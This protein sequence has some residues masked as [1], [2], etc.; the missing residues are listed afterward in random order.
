M[1][2]DGYDDLDRALAHALQLD[3]RAPFT[4]IAEVLGVSD[5]TVARRYTRLRTTGTIRVLGLTDPMAVG[6]VVWLVRVRCLPDTALAVAEALA[7]RTDTSWVN[8]LSDGTE[9]AASTRAAHGQE[10][11]ALL[12]RKLPQTPRVVG[13]SAYCV[14]HEYFGGQQSPVNK[15]GALTAE[16]IERLRPPAA[17]R[18]KGPRG[19]LG[20]ED[21]K[22]LDALARDGRTPL[23]ELVDATGWSQSTVRRRLADLRAD[24]TLYFDVDYSP[25]LFRQGVTTTMWLSVRPSE[26][27][28]T[29]QKLADHPEVAFACATTGSKNLMATVVCPDVPALYTYLTTRIAE[30]P[31][32]LDMETS[33]VL[34]RIKGPG[35]LLTPPSR[36]PWRAS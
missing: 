3:G 2:S 19:P 17:D 14:L 7:R 35:P 15:S 13:V 18:S 8:V 12:L 30:L 29:G 27:D 9:V 28:A 36:V 6:D 5:Q 1:E 11:D 23:A 31:A 22:L 33:P 10:S 20:A 25:R 34:R 16:Q 24:G 26:L 4:R 32:V 21:R